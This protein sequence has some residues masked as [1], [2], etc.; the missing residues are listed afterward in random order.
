MLSALSAGVR[1]LR[2][3]TSST[4]WQ[5][6]P[7]SHEPQRREDRALAED[8]GGADDEAARH[9]T[10]D[11]G[12]VHD[13]RRPGD[14]LAVVV[15]RRDHDD[16]GRVDRADPRVVGHED[17]AL[18]D[19]AAAAERLHHAFD[20]QVQA[21][22]VV[23]DVDPG[24][25]AVALRVEDA[26]VEVERLVDQRRPGDLRRGHRL[27]VVDRPQPVLDHL[28]GDRVELARGG[29]LA[30]RRRTAAPGAGC[31]RRRPSRSCPGGRTT[32]SPI[33]SRIAGPAIVVP[34]AS[35]SAA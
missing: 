7:P 13:D 32:V 8:L 5:Y 4:S 25:H 19:V 18:V 6:S 21:R 10:A 16:V 12:V 31:R 17:V 23:R 20:R 24:E 35:T 9:R 30:A 29:R 1:E 11:V 27:L 3:K 26:G 22:R 14:D 2:R 28:V 33:R 15:D 34:A